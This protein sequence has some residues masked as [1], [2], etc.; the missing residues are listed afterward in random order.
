MCRRSP[1]KRTSARTKDGRD[2]AG[3]NAK[4]GASPTASRPTRVNPDWTHFN[5]VA[6]N[7]ELDQIAAAL[8]PLRT[9]KRAVVDVEGGIGIGKTALMHAVRRSAT[10][11]GRA[12]DPFQWAACR[13][14]QRHAHRL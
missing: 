1:F 9:G 11:R 8:G 6:Y 2:K 10:G 4:A 7:A 5:G 12:R 14:G 13:L 3:S